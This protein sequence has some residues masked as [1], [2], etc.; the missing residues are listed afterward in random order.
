[1][2]YIGMNY[3]S[4]AYQI[5]DCLI[6]AFIIALLLMGARFALADQLPP[7]TEARY[8]G[9]TIT[10][11]A[12]EGSTGYNIYR[13]FLYLDTVIGITEYVPD[14]MGEYRIS[15]FDGN[16]NFSPLQVINADVVPTSNMVVVET[17]GASLSP[18]QNVSGIVYS[19]SAGEIFW[20][21]VIS[22]SLEYTIKINGM[23]LVR[24]TGAGFYVNS[25]LPNALNIITVAA[26]SVTGLQSEP[27][28]LFFDTRVDTFPVDASNFNLNIP[29]GLVAPPQNARIEV[30]SS[31]TAELFWD[32]PRPSEEIYITEVYRDNELL[33]TSP[34]NS[35][36]DDNRSVDTRHA[37]ELVAI[38]A[39]G[40]R[41]VPTFINPDTFD[42][43]EEFV[44]QT[45][46]AG[47]TEVTTANPH[48][49]WFPTIQAFADGNIPDG[50][51]GTI[52]G[53]TTH[54]NSLVTRMYYNCGDGYGTLTIERTNQ[55]I[56][57]HQLTFRACTINRSYFNGWV[58]IIGT[59]AGSY[60]IEYDDM[61]IFSGDLGTFFDGQ[62]SVTTRLES[63][64]QSLEYNSFEYFVFGFSPDEDNLDISVT[65]D[66]TVTFDIYAEAPTSFTTNFTAS[67]PWTQGRPLAVSTIE[68]F[69]GTDLGNGNYIFGELLAEADNGEKLLFT[70]NAG[71]DST[72]H[73]KL[74]TADST[75]E[76]S[77]NWNDLVRLPSL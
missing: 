54:D 53:N 9:Q 33:G 24:T 23:E 36:Y 6:H 55:G 68:T 21:R 26:R 69:T 60:T 46:L 51:A 39:N 25:L 34:G 49:I 58:N 72:W 74:F 59:E 70:A 17:F 67:A 64:F 40:K 45:V 14:S 75:G 7:V 76:I 16:G 44:V 13:G 27:V 31:T 32:R 15:A 63:D 5:C 50:L 62:V 73:A 38:D 10:W 65:L 29:V 18:P 61:E 4:H 56:A 37:Y 48:T 52:S 66:Q 22:R 77:G 41:S 3:R 11:Q 43:N 28:T 8:N 1:M 71:N 42:G 2:E 30:Y 57:N 19:D 12:V 20:D 47:I 35:F